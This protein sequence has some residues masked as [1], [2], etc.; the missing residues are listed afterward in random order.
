[1]EK[2]Y[3]REA[4]VTYRRVALKA[5][6]NDG[7]VRSSAHVAA[8]ASQL[9]GANLAE[10][11][12]VF[13]LSA[14]HK[15]QGYHLVG[16]G[17]V[18]GCPVDIQAAVRYPL[19]VG[20]AAIILAHNHPSGDVQPSNEDHELTRRIQAA[21]KLLGMPLLDHVIVGDGL[22]YYSFLDHDDL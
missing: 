5:T 21:C 8:I 16:R 6:A 1:M 7:P 19:L 4:Q 11:F 10:D 20:S 2:F 3:V 15:I 13:A 14:R 9:V 18:T 12:L 22:E 17:G